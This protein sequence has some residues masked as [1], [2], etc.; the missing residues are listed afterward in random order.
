VAADPDAIEDRDDGT[1]AQPGPASGTAGRVRP[2]RGRAAS[3]TWLLEAARPGARHRDAGGRAGSRRA[4]AIAVPAAVLVAVAAV[5]MALLT[6]HGPRF[7]RLAAHQAGTGTGSPRPPLTIGTYPG[8]QQRGVFAWIDRVVAYG[9]TIVTTGAQSSD[10][11]VRQQFFTSADGG[12][13]WHLAPVRSAGGGMPPLGHAATRIAGGAAGWAAVGPQAIWTSRDGLSWTLRAAH[14]IT[15]ELPGDQVWVLTNTADGFLAGGVAAAPGGGTQAVL[16]IS[17]DGVNWRRL[18]G[19]QLGLAPPGQTV[20][21]ISYAASRGNDTV[22]A[23]TVASGAAT[24]VGVWLSTD[25]G[26]SW[27]QVTV[28][29]DHGATDAL[30]GLSFDAAGLLAVRPGHTAAGAADGVAYFSP[31]GR[32]WTYAATIDP[33]GGWSPGVVKGSS[34]GFAVTGQTAAGTLVAYASAGAGTV[35]TPTGPLGTAARESMLSPAVA[36]G[37]A[38]VAAG[39]TAATRTGQQAVLVEAA[40]GGPVRPVPLAGIPGAVVPELAVNA[41]AAAGG[42]Q[43]AVGSADGLPAIWRRQPGGSWALVSAPALASGLPGSRLAALTGVTHGASGWLAVGEPGP[44]VFTSADGVTWRPAAGGIARGLAGAGAVAAA[45]GPRGYVIVGKLVAPG[46]G[47]VADVWWSPDLTSWT[48]AH[49][50]NDT[51]G[52]S[53]VLAVAADARGFVSVGSHDGRPAAWTTSDGRSWTTIVLPVPGG[54]TSAVLQQVAID[55]SRVA[56]LG[57]AATAGGMVPFAAMSPDGGGRWRQVPFASPGPDTV[58]TALIAGPGGFAAAGQYGPPGH[59]EPA[60]WTSAAAMTWA[61]SQ[62]RG[63]TGAAA[64]QA[65]RITALAPSGPGVTGIGSIAAQRSQEAFTVSVPS[66]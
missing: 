46:G 48:R 61:R 26:T 62:L 55:G 58:F 42:V 50:V 54:A 51:S 19:A 45:A 29:A 33:A 20:Q 11:V 1:G 6:G 2:E 30:A 3:D 12:A 24:H 17:R 31:N 47:C 36:P 5:A 7:G 49:D 8:Q 14:G 43:V 38:V 23:G 64:G 27:A 34:Y 28:P 22:I 16:W 25:G 37:G 9:R 66:R 32:D 57:Q 40:P 53:Q 56:A 63:L 18:T 52:S 4:A 59:T 44:L 15:P 60:A 10:G 21:N 13:S 41:M 39:S 35:W 65:Y